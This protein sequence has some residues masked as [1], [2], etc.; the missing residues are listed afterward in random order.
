MQKLMVTVKNAAGKEEMKE[1]TVLRSWATASGAS[2]Y[3]HHGTGIYGYLDG[4]PVRTEME[5]NIVDNPAQHALAIR[6]WKFTGQAKSEAF[7]AAKDAAEV[8]RMGDFQASGQTPETELDYVM[9]QTSKE[10]APEDWSPPVSW[11]E[12]FAARP[13]WWGQAEMIVFKGVAYRR[14]VDETENIP[15]QGLPAGVVETPVDAKD[16]A[17]GLETPALDLK[18][19]PAEVK[20][21][22]VDVKNTP[23]KASGPAAKPKDALAKKSTIKAKEI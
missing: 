15:A 8:A 1:V 18:G 22:G 12:L 4:S 13:D 10:H 19:S 3:L 23:D 20:A 7:Y 21:T 2:L 14:A 5:L 11:V 6:W 16:V 9:Y 17:S